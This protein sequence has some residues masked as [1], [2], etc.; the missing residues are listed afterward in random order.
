MRKA[1][2][3]VVL[4]HNFNGNSR[5]EMQPINSTIGASARISKGLL[6]EKVSEQ[7]WR[8][9]MAICVV[10]GKTLKMTKT[11]RISLLLGSIKYFSISLNTFK[12]P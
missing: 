8:K 3:F 2:H 11:D 10:Q 9:K 1:T 6:K 7:F 4:G 12:T 5:K